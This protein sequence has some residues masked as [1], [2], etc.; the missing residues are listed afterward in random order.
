MR[1]SVQAG[2]RGAATGSEYIL[3]LDDDILLH[4][5]M[6]QDLVAK[7]ECD[8]SWFMATGSLPLLYYRPFIPIHRIL[9]LIP[10]GLY[11]CQALSM[12]ATWMRSSEA[13]SV[14]CHLSAATTP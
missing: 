13:M 11:P 12:G 9:A 4:P 7:L 6:L 3:C 2:I 8:P 1:R 5:G 14:E 10:S